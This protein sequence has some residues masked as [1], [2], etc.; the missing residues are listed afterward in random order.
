VCEEFFRLRAGGADWDSIKEMKP[1]KR[2]L[3]LVWDM[4]DMKSGEVLKVWNE[5]IHLFGDAFRALFRKKRAWM[6]YGD[7]EAGCIIEIT[8]KEKKMGQTGGC[9]DCSQSIL[10][11]PRPESLPDWV[12]EAAGSLCPDDWLVETSYKTLKEMMNAVVD[13][14]E[15]DEEEEEEEEKPTKTKKAKAVKVKE[16]EPEEDDDDEEEEEES[17]DDDEEEPEDDDDDD[18][19]ED[20]AP[21]TPPE[22]PSRPARGGKTKPVKPTVEDDED[23]EPEPEEEKPAPKPTRKPRK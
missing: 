9:V 2:E 18:D 17:E 8:G 19:E 6:C 12:V 1:K 21:S 14:E 22:K 15:E 3:F 13:S 4:D 11:E 7:L 20:E 5:S 23:E 16:P 10:I